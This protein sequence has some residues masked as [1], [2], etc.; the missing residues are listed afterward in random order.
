MARGQHSCGMEYRAPLTRRSL[1]AAGA[2]T[3]ALVA[4]RVQATRRVS[5]A[6]VPE[7][8]LIRQLPR[9][10]RI[11]GVPG[12]GIAVAAG[13]RVV[14]RQSFG[15]TNIRTN[16]P[17]TDDT[18]FEAASMTKPAFA[19]VVMNLVDEGRIA[20]DRQL[21][22]YLRPAYLG[23]DPALNRITVRDVL[24]HSTGL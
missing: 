24:R 14:W 3:S 6:W 12:V 2:A 23:N 19:Y 22:N 7:P 16:D 1:L 21:V 18:L 15:V 13:G 8:A 11:A 20:L 4:S 5:R 10:M 17:V 9:L